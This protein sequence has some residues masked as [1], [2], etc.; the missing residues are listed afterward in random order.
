RINLALRE[1]PDFTGNLTEEALRGTLVIAPSLTYL[2]KAF[3]SVKYGNLSDKPYLEVTI[4]TLADPSLAP[5]GKHVL[6]IWLQYAPYRGDFDSQRVLELALAQL[7]EFTPNLRSTVLHAQVL[8][9][10]DY[11]AQFNLTEGHLYGGDMT[12][13]QT[14]FL[15]P[16]PGFAQYQSPIE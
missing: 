6:S 3:D 12:L 9:S 10:R 13:A 14:F 5:A 8:T 1:L 2:E 16:I 4:P 15:R 7:S 11:E